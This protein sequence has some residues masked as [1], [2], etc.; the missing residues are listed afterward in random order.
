MED[1]D[2]HHRLRAEIAVWKADGLI[3]D[4]QAAAIRQRYAGD[5]AVAADVDVATDDVA[6]GGVIGNRVAKPGG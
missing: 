2:F 5:A 6:P 4:D 3:S 1:S